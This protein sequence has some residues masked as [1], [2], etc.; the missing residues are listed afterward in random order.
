MTE[1]SSSRGRC[2]LTREQLMKDTN[3]KERD[4][5]FINP[6]LWDDNVE[7]PDDEVDA[8][9]ATTYIAR[10]IADYTDRP[11]ADEELFGEF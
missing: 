2:E 10:A 6:E 1:S 3:L 9:E 4:W 7:A 11:T 8:I 5:R